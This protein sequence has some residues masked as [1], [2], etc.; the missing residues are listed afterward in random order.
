MDITTLFTPEE[1]GKE[2]ELMR[3]E[4]PLLRPLDELFPYASAARFVCSTKEEFMNVMGTLTVIQRILTKKR[5]GQRE[6]ST[7]NPLPE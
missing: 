6:R 4:A 2:L 5:S 7:P 3:D 1:F